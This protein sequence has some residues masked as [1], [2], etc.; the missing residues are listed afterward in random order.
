MLSWMI[1]IWMKYHLGKPLGKSIIS[2]QDL[3]GSTC[4]VGFTLSVGDTTPRSTI[5]SVERDNWNC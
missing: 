5:I 1:E 4:G 3:Q 2:K